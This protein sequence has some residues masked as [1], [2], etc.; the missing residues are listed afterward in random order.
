[1]SYVRYAALVLPTTSSELADDE[2]RGGKPGYPWSLQVT[3]MRGDPDTS[4]AQTE[5]VVRADKHAF[6]ADLALHTRTLMMSIRNSNQ[7]HTRVLAAHALS[8]SCRHACPVVV[9]DP[10]EGRASRTVY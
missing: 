7:Q 4:V 5:A 10:G 8:S 2:A 1:M 3:T 9:A 6:A